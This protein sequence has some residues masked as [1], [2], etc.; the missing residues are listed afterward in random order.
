MSLVTAAIRPSGAS[1]R[2]DLLARKTHH[3][4]SALIDDLL[5]DNSG[6]LVYQEDVIAFLQQVCGL[7]GSEADTIRR[8][9]AKKDIG[10]L[11]NA[12]PR[13]LDGYCAK[14]DK[15]AEEAAQECQEFLKVI[16]DASSYM[17]NYSHSIAYCL[18]GYLCAY[19]RYYHPLEFITAFLNNA[20]NDE[21]LKN[22]A[23]MAKQ[24]GIRVVPPKFGISRSDYAYDK[25]SMT[26]AKGLASIKHMGKKVT[27]MLYETSRKKKYDC[28]TDL[29][30]DICARSDYD[31]RHLNSRQLSILIHIDF[32]SDFGNQRE[33]D[34]IVSFWELFKRGEAKQIRK[35]KVDGLFIEE[36]IR[37]YSTD[38]RKDGSEAASY[39]LNDVPAI[40]RACE[41]KVLSLG[42]SDYSVISKVKSFNEAMGYTGYMSGRD[43]DRST[44]FVKDVMPVKRK[45]DGKQFGYGVLTQSIGSG[46]ESRF[47]V[48]NPVYN[49]DPIHKG[50][51]IRCVRYRRDPGGYFTLEQYIHID[52]DT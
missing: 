32:F 5:K 48:F 28:F 18:L 39:T 9:I 37:Q 45:R 46:I 12:L 30:Q 34:N 44:L 42:L 49:N 40:I 23:L 10:I 25:D 6:Y 15:P 26:I 14:S 43:E 52:D 2:D 8:G 17:F 16:E 11:N 21:D 47:T 29:L 4:P 50:D 3:N 51:V 20:A 19:Y 13:I 24:Y 38:R 36:I 22:G 41:Q 27:D 35:D 33:L 31:T 7:G 1:Y